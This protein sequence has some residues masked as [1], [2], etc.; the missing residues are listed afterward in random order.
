MSD[1]DP[2]MA[3]NVEEARFVVPETVV[4][5]V[6]PEAVEAPVTEPIVVPEG[7]IKTVLGWV[8]DDATKAKTAL[9]A[10]TK[11]EKRSSL[12][13]KLESIIN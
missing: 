7:S 3:P 13:S 4:E 2:Y 10:E 11:G 5:P 6:A 12:I 8:G 1:T 9:S